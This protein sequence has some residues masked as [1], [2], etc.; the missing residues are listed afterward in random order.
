MIEAFVD[1]DGLLQNVDGLAKRRWMTN[2]KV[3]RK[4]SEK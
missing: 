2:A 4:E 1:A 3:K